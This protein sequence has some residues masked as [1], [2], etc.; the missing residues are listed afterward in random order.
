ML[1][2]I[3][4]LGHFASAAGFWDTAQS[5]LTSTGT[6]IY[7]DSAET[8]LPKIIGS[9]IKA[10]IGFL[11][12]V[13]LVLIIWGGWEYM[14]SGGEKAKAEAARKRIINAVIG[15]AI[16]L[17]AYALTSF[18]IGSLITATAPAAP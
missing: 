17:A 14:A 8:D 6:Q 18:I 16:I 12:I 7:G 5:G 15:L 4:V 2:G 10:V 9:I 3:L 1:V 11:G 13:M